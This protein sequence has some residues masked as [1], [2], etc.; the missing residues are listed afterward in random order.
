MVVFDGVDRQ[1]T[2]VGDAEALCGT[3]L[4]GGIDRV[5]FNVNRAPAAARAVHLI[6]LHSERAADLTACWTARA[7]VLSIVRVLD[8]GDIVARDRVVTV[9][10]PNGDAASLQGQH[11][12]VLDRAA[13]KVESERLIVAAFVSGIRRR[14]SS[15]IVVGVRSI[16]PCRAGSR[17]GW[18][19]VRHSNSADIVVGIQRR[20]G[21]CESA[22]RSAVEDNV[23]E[24][25]RAGERAPFLVRRHSH[26]VVAAF[27]RRDFF[28]V[29][30][31]IVERPSRR[32]TVVEIITFQRGSAVGAEVQVQIVGRSGVSETPA[33]EHDVSATIEV[34]R[35][36]AVQAA[37][38]CDLSILDGSSSG[39]GGDLESEVK[40]AGAGSIVTR[41]APGQYKAV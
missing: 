16:A 24:G 12:I 19:A 6:E 36:G 30:I 20:R 13:L 26:A 8:H 15:L 40:R 17:P 21:P 41:G 35:A 29:H 31:P 39:I 5:V 1:R 27:L 14:S 2:G 9:L 33:I 32:R 34:R 23:V 7:V 18:L 3:V 4:C 28:V 25:C 37:T 22:L 10:R 11:C 38:L